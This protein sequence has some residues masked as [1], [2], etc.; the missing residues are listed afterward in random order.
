VVP[1][2]TGTTA[3]RI[4]PNPGTKG[5]RMDQERF[6]RLTRRLSRVSSRR[7]ALQSL[8][9]VVLAGGLARFGLAEANAQDATAARCLGEG[10]KCKR[11]NQC[12]SGLC[13][14]KK[15]KKRC[16]R[17]PGQSIC[18]VRDDICSKPLDEEGVDCGVGSLSCTCMVTAAGHAFCSNGNQSTVRCATDVEC[19]AAIG[20]GAACVHQRTGRCNNGEPV[21]VCHFPCPDPV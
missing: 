18:T 14:G 5:T 13:Q 17:A 6:D 11:G 1:G 10:K 19:V 9:G 20:A 15:D 4:H 8:A 3:P 12:C 2:Y 16:R 7:V 21:N